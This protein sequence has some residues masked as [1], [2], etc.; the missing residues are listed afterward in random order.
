M[1]GAH[2]WL[3]SGCYLENAGASSLG[4]AQG[5]DS[6]LGDLKQPHIVCDGSDHNADLVLL[7]ISQKMHQELRQF[8]S[9][10][11]FKLQMEVLV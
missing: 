11:K 1:R 10:Y 6:E 8:M 4:E 2:E 9:G 5:A 7:Y 3:G